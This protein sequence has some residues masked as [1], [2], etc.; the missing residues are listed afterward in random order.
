MRACGRVRGRVRVRV[1]VCVCACV[2]VCVCVC[3]CACAYTLGCARACAYTLA[4][5]C[6]Y[7][8]AC[9]CAYTLACLCLCLCACARAR[10]CV[11]ACVYACVSVRQTIRHT[12]AYTYSNVHLDTDYVC[13]C[14]VSVHSLQQ[15][16][17]MEKYDKR[18]APSCR[19]GCRT[20]K[21]STRPRTLI[22]QRYSGQHTNGQRYNE[23]SQQNMLFKWTSLY[24]S[25]SCPSNYSPPGP[26]WAASSPL[27]SPWARR[28]AQW[29]EQLAVEQLQ[30][31]ERAMEI[32]I[33]K[34]DAQ[35]ARRTRRGTAEGRQQRAMRNTHTTRRAH[36]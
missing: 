35:H 10:V 1:C 11:F 28:N 20:A 32:L 21:S 7:T 30:T 22:R 34:T 15:R 33:T 31:A 18:N 8:S 25:A 16:T 9:A 3:A 2:C 24:G 12:H 17:L 29:K 19:H 6:A 26:P 14:L 27:G 36:C 23:G 13:M 5:A 4:C